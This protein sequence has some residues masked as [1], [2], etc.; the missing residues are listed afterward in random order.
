MG[1]AVERGEEGRAV[2]LYAEA[3]CP[4]FLERLPAGWMDLGRRVSVCFDGVFPLFCMFIRS[5][6]WNYTPI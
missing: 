5:C 2:L 6:L 3:A 1:M 4:G